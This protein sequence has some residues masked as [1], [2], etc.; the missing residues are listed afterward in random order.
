MVNEDKVQPSDIQEQERLKTLA[1]YNI[2]DTPTEQEFDELTT[3][4]SLICGTPISL[5]TLITHDRQWFKSRTGVDVPET[6][7]S[8]SFCQHAILE[9]E[10]FEVK[11]AM[12]DT[13]FQDN[14]LVTGSP[15][16]RFYA[17]SQLVASNGHK[18]GTLCVIDTVPKTLTEEQKYALSVLAKQVVANFELRL[19][20]QELEKEKQQLKEANKKLDQFVHMV[21]HDLKEPVMNISSVTEWLQDDLEAQD[22]S[23][24]SDNLQ[25][26]KERTDAMQD[27]IEGL[28][29]YAFAQVQDLP[30]EEVNVQRLLQGILENHSGSQGFHVHLAP[31][32][33]TLQTEKVLL[34][35]VFA[36]LISNAFKYHHTGKGNLWVQAAK[37]ENTYTFQVRDDGPGIAPRHHEKVFGMYERLLRDA[38]STKG[39]GI[40]LATV[41]KIVEDKGGRIWIDSDLGRGSTF[42]FTWPA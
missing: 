13:R 16:I 25:L 29:Q 42:F 30:K 32:L 28:L 21:S 39:S 5:I 40:G 12:T 4:A 37:Q 23:G 18:L 6:P 22:Y 36:N 11:D 3:L 9:D 17:G 38:N 1:A 26:I 19:K 7:R 35:Q 33:P 34:Q 15:N 24:L 31:D 2:L 41:K 27:I 8:I 14:P 20:Q 10:I